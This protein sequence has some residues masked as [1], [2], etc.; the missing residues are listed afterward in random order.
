MRLDV[1]ADGWPRLPGALGQ[2]SRAGQCD[3]RSGLGFVS[4]KAQSTSLVRDACTQTRTHVSVHIRCTHSLVRAHTRAHTGPAAASLRIG[5]GFLF[6]A[7]KENEGRCARLRSV[8]SEL[9]K[10]MLSALEREGEWMGVCSCPGEEA[11]GEDGAAAAFL[12]PQGV[13]S[14]DTCCLRVPAQGQAASGSGLVSC[15]S[16]RK[17]PRGGASR[18]GPQQRVREALLL[19]GLCHP[20]TELAG[21]SGSGILR[22]DKEVFH[23]DLG[24][25]SSCRPWTRRGGRQSRG[26]VLC[27]LKGVVCTRACTCVCVRV[28]GHA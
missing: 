8:P 1:R 16:G 2:A 23:E 4:V 11:V 24:R 10:F 18:W 19:I 14:P 26:P 12:G 20:E 7:R 28:P 25:L 27:L 3:P 9:C 5:N 6:W 22:R 17:S 15:S 13:L 21:N